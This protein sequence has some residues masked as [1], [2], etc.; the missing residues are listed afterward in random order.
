MNVDEFVNV[1]IPAA[2]GAY[3]LGWLFG[4]GLYVFRR[5][6]VTAIGN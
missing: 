3:F 1:G 6:L 2:L 5:F 4:Y